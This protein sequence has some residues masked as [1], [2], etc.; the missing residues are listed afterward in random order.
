MTDKKT[1]LLIDD[2]QIKQVVYKAELELEDMYSRHETCRDKYG[3][4]PLEYIEH[5]K[6]K[7]E[8]LH[9]LEK[10]RERLQGEGYHLI[11]YEENSDE[12]ICIVDGEF[13]FEQM[14]KE[15]GE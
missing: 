1:D 15:I 11:R 12:Q 14:M 5:R 3:R 8:A 9:L 13:K 10:V 4:S 6:I 7:A 2:H